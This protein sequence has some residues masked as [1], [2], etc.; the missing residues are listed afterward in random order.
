MLSSP[1]EWHP[2][3]HVGRA[4]KSWS[5]TRRPPVSLVDGRVP[6]CPPLGAL[7]VLNQLKMNMS[8]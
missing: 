4:L 1:S 8:K 6:G 3:L 5:G 7:L 2:E